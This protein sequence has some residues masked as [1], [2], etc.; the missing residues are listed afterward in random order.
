MADSAWIEAM[1][2]ELHQ[3]DRLQVWELVDKPFS[4]TEEVYVARPDRFVDPDHPEKVYHL[5]KYLYGLKQA[6]RAWTSDPPIPTSTK[7][8]TRPLEDEALHQKSKGGSL[9][10][11]AEGEIDDLT[12]EQYLTLT[13]GN[14]APGVV[15][16]KIR[17]N[18]NFK[19]KSQFMRELR[20]DTFSENKNDD[21]HEHVERGVDR[22]SP[23]TIDSWDILK[24]SFIQRYC[25]PSKAAEQLEDIRNFKQEGDET[26]YKAW[27]TCLI[28][29]QLMKSIAIIRSINNN[30]SN[31]KGITAIVSK[32]DSLGQDMKKLKEN[33][34]AIQVGCQ[35]CR[36]A[37]LDKECPQNKEIKS[38]SLKN[39]ETQIEQL[40]KEFHAKTVSEVNNSSF[41]QCKAVYDDKE[42]P[43]N[44]KINEPHEVSFV[45][46]DRPYVVQEEGVSSKILSCQL[47]RKELNL[48]NFTLPCT[49]GILNFYAMADLGASINVI[50]KSMF[51]HLKLARLKKINMLVEMADMTKRVPIGIVENVLIKI[52]KF[53]FPSDFV[54]IDIY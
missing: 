49:I 28:S 33:I 45:S 18:L 20:E 14:Q 54:V 39:L 38:A 21:A 27:E 13:R 5:R 43:L 48:G 44:N 42:A 25:P 52:D 10:I 24:K 51:E 19:I 3:F 26:L 29:A 32:L 23:G 50:P 6:P 9:I 35:I 36:G 8:R 4:K 22:L 41:D 16:P 37:H 31:T 53:L 30:N 17:G 34:H 7:R 12:I 15:I 40:T 47:P 1:Q 2:D 46:N 11:M